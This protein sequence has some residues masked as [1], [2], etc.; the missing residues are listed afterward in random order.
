M[1]SE[2]S[3]PMTVL[4]EPESHGTVVLPVPQARSTATLGRMRCVFAA[5]RID[6]RNSS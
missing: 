5:L 1:A 4:A 6:T 3:T 2:Q